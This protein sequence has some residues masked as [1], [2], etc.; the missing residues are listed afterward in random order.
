MIH[1]VAVRYRGCM[2]IIH[3][4]PALVVRTRW[5]QQQNIPSMDILVYQTTWPRV[6]KKHINLRT[7]TVLPI[8]LDTS[9]NNLLI[10]LRLIGI[11]NSTQS[12][13]LIKGSVN[14]DSYIKQ[15]IVFTACKLPVE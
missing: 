12:T 9:V 7:H 2:Y 3:S 1:S 6:K 4:E 15:S 10:L 14:T 11:H 5:R 13:D 8:L